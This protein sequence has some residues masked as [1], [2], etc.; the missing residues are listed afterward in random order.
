MEPVANAP[1]PMVIALYVAGFAV[2]GLI[3][4][5]ALWVLFADELRRRRTPGDVPDAVDFP[6]GPGLP[7]R[8]ARS[9]GGYSP[10][11]VSTRAPAPGARASTGTSP[12]SS[13]RASASKP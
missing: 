4:L 2:A 13:S 6:A 8:T 11:S 9:D 12:S 1:Q 3:N 7:R 10:T 5:Y